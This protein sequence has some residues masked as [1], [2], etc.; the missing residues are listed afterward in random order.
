MACHTGWVRSRFADS[1]GATLQRHFDGDQDFLNH[2]F[3]MAFGA[4]YFQTTPYSQPA[5]LAIWK[6]IHYQH[7]RAQTWQEMR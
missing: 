4:P 3:L 1:N 2:W 7:Y 5:R 6:L